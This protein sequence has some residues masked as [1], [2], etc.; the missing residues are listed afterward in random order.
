MLAVS[1][2]ILKGD[3]KRLRRKLRFDEEA[4][5]GLVV[6]TLPCR[7]A[8]QRQGRPTMDRPLFIGGM[9]NA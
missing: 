5:Q 8:Q 6:N 3:L 1:F 7:V 2:E 4:G 9:E